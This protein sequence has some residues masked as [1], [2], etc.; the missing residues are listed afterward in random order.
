MNGLCDDL[1][2]F[3]KEIRPYGKQKIKEN[4]RKNHK[5]GNIDAVVWNNGQKNSGHKD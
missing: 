3:L 2:G 1:F 4:L 5:I